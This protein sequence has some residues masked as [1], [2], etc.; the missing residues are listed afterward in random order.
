ME[1]SRAEQRELATGINEY[2]GY[3]DVAITGMAND[4][5]AAGY[6]LHKYP[7]VFGLAVIVIALAAVWLFAK[8]TLPWARA[9]RQ[10][11][12]GNSLRAN[13]KSLRLVI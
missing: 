1:I 8:D 3:G 9:Y 2:D 7:F 4:H 6:D 11:R 13:I 10:R 5:L 12:Y